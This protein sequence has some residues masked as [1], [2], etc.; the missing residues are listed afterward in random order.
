MVV[1]GIVAGVG[2]QAMPAKLTAS[3]VDGW[4]EVGRVLARASRSRRTCQQMAACVADDRQLG[5]VEAEVSLLAR[6]S[7]VMPGGVTG[8]QPRRI[9]GSF[10]LALNQSQSL[11]MA[12]DRS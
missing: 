10:R 12:K 9:D 3:L 7:H 11:G 5:P 8:F 6:A 4:K 2:Q 1:F